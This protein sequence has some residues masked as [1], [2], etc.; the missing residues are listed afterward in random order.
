MGRGADRTGD[1]LRVDVAE[2][3]HRQPDRGELVAEI[4]QADPGLDRHP[5]GRG[6][7]VLDGVHR[8]E[9]EQHTVRH[10][11]RRE[12]VTGT[13]GLDALSG[14]AGLGDDRRHLVG[15]RRLPD[16]DGTHV[17]FLAQLRTVAPPETILDDHARRR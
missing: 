9:R 13:D 6:V 14:S 16:G 17:W 1:R 10:R 12:R 8:V 5:A 11:R 2:V 7:D 3:G 15:G 4:P